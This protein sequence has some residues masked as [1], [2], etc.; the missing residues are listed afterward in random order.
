MSSHTFGSTLRQEVPGYVSRRNKA[1][2]EFIFSDDHLI[3]RL[4]TQHGTADERTISWRFIPSSHHFRQI[5]ALPERALKSL[6]YFSLAALVLLFAQR[7]DSDA[8]KAILIFVTILYAAFGIYIFWRWKPV[9]TIPVDDWAIEVHSGNG[10][11]EIIQAILEHRKKYFL[12]FSHIKEDETIRQ[13]LKRLRWLTEIEVL[14]PIE[15][16]RLQDQMLPAS[17]QNLLRPSSDTSIT[18]LRQRRNFTFVKVEFHAAHFQYHR[19]GLST[20]SIT[21]NLDYFGLPKRPLIAKRFTSQWLSLALFSIA[22]VA[23]SAVAF[24]LDPDGTSSSAWIL[25]PNAAIW[26]AVFMQRVVG[27]KGAEIF[28]GVILLAGAK[29]DSD[30]LIWK[31]LEARKLIALLNRAWLDPLATE[32]EYKSLLEGLI[33]QQVITAEDSEQFLAKA[34]MQAEPTLDNLSNA[35]SDS[36]SAPTVH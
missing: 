4:Q 27:F 11:D 22:M 10:H 28:R 17:K 25:L 12:Q 32:E 36:L 18:V 26:S 31:E 3:C 6:T 20:G 13:N 23:T 29:P 30:E 33:G 1:V 19:H 21:L 15:F 7:G 5:I 34:R 14:S 16:S 9:T 35:A 2:R 24:W 8:I